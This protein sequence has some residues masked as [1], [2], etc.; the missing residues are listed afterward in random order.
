MRT[1]FL[2]SHPAFAPGHCMIC[3]GNVGP[4]I[5]TAVDIPGDGRMYICTRLCLALMIEQVEGIA[6]RR[7]C[8]ATRADGSPCTAF[9]LTN[10][11]YCVAHS[12]Q[13]KEEKDERLVGSEVR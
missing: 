1:P 10:R 7:V 8:S 3:G 12:K 9:A 13:E 6:I 2:V 5:D 4:M 11:A